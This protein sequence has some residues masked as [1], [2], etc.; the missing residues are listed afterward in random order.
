MVTRRVPLLVAL[1]AD[2]LAPEMSEGPD[3]EVV[4][5]QHFASPPLTDMNL[6]PTRTTYE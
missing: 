2:R 1:A 6:S 4:L 3:G 5:F